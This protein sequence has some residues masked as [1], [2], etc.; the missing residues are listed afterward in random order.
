MGPPRKRIMDIIT[1]LF[2]NLVSIA[3][4]VAAYFLYP[5][6]LVLLG[7]LHHLILP[8]DTPGNMIHVLYCCSHVVI[9]HENIS[10]VIVHV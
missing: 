5:R 7:L 10:H 2:G 4:V 1:S 3:T 6:M 8:L 9:M